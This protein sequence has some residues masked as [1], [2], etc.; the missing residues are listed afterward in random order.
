M[1]AYGADNKQLLSALLHLF[2]HFR[3]SCFMPSLLFKLITF[4]IPCHFQTNELYQ[5]AVVAFCLLSAWV[6]LNTVLMSPYLKCGGYSSEANCRIYMYFFFWNILVKALWSGDYNKQCQRI[7]RMFHLILQCSDKLG[8]SLELGSFVA[9]V[10]I[11][12]TDFAQ[13][14][15]DQ[16]LIYERMLLLSFFY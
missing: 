3:A 7:L 8:L 13:H 15:L 11:S 1:P 2:V 10:M 9:G 5:L 4:W 6:S 14:T 12:T 16:V